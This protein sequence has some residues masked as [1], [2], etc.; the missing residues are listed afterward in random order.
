MRIL[1]ISDVHGN[2]AAL[3]AVLHEP[4]DA[5]LCL[6]DLVG[7]GPEPGE[8]VERVR[9]AAQT[10][11][12][13]NHDYALVT[14]LPPGCR[15]EYAAL[16]A[17]TTRLGTD[18]LS[19]Q[20]WAWLGTRPRWSF[21]EADGIRYL[22][23]HGTPSNPLH[24]YLGP[25]TA[26]WSRETAGTDADVILT[27]HTHLPFDLVAESRRVVNPG[28]VGLPKDGDPRASYAVIEGGC[29]ELKRLAYP[30]QDTV[31]ALER[32]G[33]EADAVTALVALLST[34]SDTGIHRPTAPGPASVERDLRGTRQA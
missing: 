34:G 12:L 1:V 31:R 32:S 21:W 17:A 22:L 15:R 4:H 14:G 16:A 23:V 30:V 11:T 10:A 25:D 2:L 24:R 26:Q 29:V 20:S 6:G 18:Q 28:S 9:S 8:C 33:V 7:Y 5:L 27:G 19:A 3:D 13:G